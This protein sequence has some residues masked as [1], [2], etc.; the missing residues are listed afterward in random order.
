MMLQ[1]RVHEL[2]ARIEQQR[3]QLLVLIRRIAEIR[4]TVQEIREMIERLANRTSRP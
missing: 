3:K 2:E 4:E 1:H